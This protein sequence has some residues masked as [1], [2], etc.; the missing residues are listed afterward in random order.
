MG[1]VVPFDGKKPGS[2][3]PAPGDAASLMAFYVAFPIRWREFLHAHF[4][5]AGHVATFFGVSERAAAKWWDGAGGVNG[6]KVALACAT[7]PTAAPM[8]FAAE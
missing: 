7:I 3:A 2:E 4:A 1:Q 5:D 8:L 6:G